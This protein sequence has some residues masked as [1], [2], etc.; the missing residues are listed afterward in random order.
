M[1]ERVKVLAVQAKRPEFESPETT[2]KP[3]RIICAH[4]LS[5]VGQRQAIPGAFWPVS[6]D[7]TGRSSFNEGSYFKI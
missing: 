1:I 5:I 4:S 7:E 2:E 6:L 3:D